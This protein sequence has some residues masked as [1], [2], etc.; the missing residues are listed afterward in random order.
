MFNLL[1]I[2]LFIFYIIKSAIIPIITPIK[3][4]IDS[5]NRFSFIFLFVLNNSRIPRPLPG[6]SPDNRWPIVISL[7]KYNSVMI[8]LLAQLGINPIRLAK[9]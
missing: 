5:I 3:Y 7:D 6:K 8:T 1:A 9:K 4:S 2:V